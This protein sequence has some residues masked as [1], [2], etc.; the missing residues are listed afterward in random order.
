MISWLTSSSSQDNSRQPF[1]G[2]DAAKVQL[3][4]PTL[5]VS[6]SC[7]MAATEAVNLASM[8]RISVGDE[9]LVCWCGG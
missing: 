1:V 7:D 6:E 9:A 4:A 5:C 8:A 3:V 2:G